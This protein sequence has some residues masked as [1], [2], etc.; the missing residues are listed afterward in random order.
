[1]LHEVRIEIIEENGIKKKQ[2]LGT[3]A[4]RESEELPQY[5]IQTRFS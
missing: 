1:M 4:I 3:N 2:L 5:Q